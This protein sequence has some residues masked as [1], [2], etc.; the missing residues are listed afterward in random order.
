MTAIF[1]AAALLLT[2]LGF[3]AALVVVLRAPRLAGTALQLAVDLWLAAGLLRL[4]EP[5]FS[6]AAAAAA[7]LLVK[8]LLAAGLRRG[9]SARA[10]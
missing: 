7:L 3:V 2:A 5:S 8:R 4:A 9:A 6:R 1:D 10:A